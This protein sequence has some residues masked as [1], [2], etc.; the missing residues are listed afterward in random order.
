MIET[1]SPIS[2]PDAHELADLLVLQR[3]GV[4]DGAWFLIRNPDLAQGGHDPLTHFHRY[5]WR[6]N[7]QPNLYFDAGWYIDNNRDVAALGS[8]PLLHYI[9]YGEAENRAPIA[10]FD[11]AW[12]R[13]RYAVP[14]GTLCLA[15]FL[16]HRARGVVSP[17]PEFDA[18]HYLTRYPDVA[19]AGMDPFEH[20]LVRGAAED[21]EP[22]ASF[23]PVFYR[24]RYLKHLP[25][26][27]PL[28]HFRQ[29][30]HQP[31]IHP[32]RPREE[33]DIPREVRRNTSPGPLFEDAAPL[34][35][36]APLLAKL[37]AFYLP[38]FHAVAENDLW[39]GKGFTE[40]TNVQR[41]LPRF[42][43]HYQPRTP[44]DLGHYSLAGTDV[45][46]RQ[47]AMARAAGLHGFIFYFY[48]FNGRRLLDS[49]LEQLLADPSIELPFCLMWAET[50][51]CP[52]LNGF[53]DP[54]G[55]QASPTIG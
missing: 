21:R 4:F 53:A 18:G 13:Q 6:E 9:E 30:Q 24:E 28:L 19:E 22:S 10:Y 46:K 34:P 7:R 25:D 43:G 39:W 41:G 37:L 8:N 2:A 35:P 33:T 42:A 40:W 27:V 14:R 16:Q 31:G 5:G 1:N 51:D 15:H 44:R 29:N 38:Q 36:G 11:P 48:S 17:I 12:Y 45:L 50:R 49:P 20:Y 52:E 26:C 54:C 23:D 47:A 55:T 3:S 32:R